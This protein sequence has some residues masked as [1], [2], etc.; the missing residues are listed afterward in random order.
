MEDKIDKNTSKESQQARQERQIRQLQQ[1]RD[2]YRRQTRNK[3]SD[4]RKTI[5]TIEKIKT[6][7]IGK[8]FVRQVRHREN[9]K[10]NSETASFIFSTF[11]S[12]HRKKFDL[13]VD[14]WFEQRTDRT[15]FK[16]THRKARRWKMVERS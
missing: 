7:Q 4:K 8:I 15:R 5:K 11:R 10:A 12:F 3:T 9:G 13:I 6:S 16:G 14:H 1:V 2:K